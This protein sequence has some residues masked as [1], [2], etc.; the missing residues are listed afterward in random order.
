M[1]TTKVYGPI[2]EIRPFLDHSITM[3]YMSTIPD[4]GGKIIAG[5]PAQHS[6][7][8][9]TAAGHS[10]MQDS[11]AGQT[12]PGSRGGGTHGR[13]VSTGLCAAW[14]V[15]APAAAGRPSRAVGSRRLG[16][17]VLQ[18]ATKRAAVPTAMQSGMCYT[19]CRTSSHFLTSLAKVPIK[20]TLLHLLGT[21][22]P[23]P[24]HR[25]CVDRRHWC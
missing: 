2:G 25:I 12:V 19:S 10:A 14:R 20:L 1:S 4:Q 17:G 15:V 7:R 23:P 18:P 11:P 3:H 21:P 13:G 22:L 6:C 24:I 16:C 8:T 5:G 9:A